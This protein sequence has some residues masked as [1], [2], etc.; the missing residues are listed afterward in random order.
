MLQWMYVVRVRRCTVPDEEETRAITLGSV[1]VEMSGDAVAAFRPSIIEARPAAHTRR[2]SQLL[3]LDVGVRGG[4]LADKGRI[5]PT[6][7]SHPASLQD[8][9]GRSRLAH[10]ASRCT[11]QASPSATRICNV[12]V[13][14]AAMPGQVKPGPD[15]LCY[16][17]Q[18]CHGATVQLVRGSMHAIAEGCVCLTCGSWSRFS[19]M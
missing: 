10:A 16:A 7:G 17:Q 15:V 2:W 12:H 19:A 3:S 4:R 5:I 6:H 9:T 13:G 14:H 11:G 8:G 18:A 1:L